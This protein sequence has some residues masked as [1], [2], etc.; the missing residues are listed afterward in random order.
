MVAVRHLGFVERILEPSTKSTEQNLVG[1]ATVVLTNFNYL[2]HLA[3]KRLFTPKKMFILGEE[4][5]SYS[6][7]CN[8]KLAS[9]CLE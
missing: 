9:R 3:C 4:T 5:L 1:I 2:V 7:S 6:H 8:G